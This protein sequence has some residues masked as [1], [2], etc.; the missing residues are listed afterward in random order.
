MRLTPLTD[1]LGAEVEDIDLSRPLADVDLATL[2]DAVAN[3][4][5]L[6]FRN[7]R[8]SDE[9]LLDFSAQFGQ[10]DIQPGYVPKSADTPAVGGERVAKYVAVISN[11][12]D[13]GKPIGGLGDGEAVWHADMT[14][15]PAPPAI[16]ALYALEVPPEGGDTYFLSLNH[17]FETLPEALR[18]RVQK[19]QLKHDFTYNSAGEVRRG[20]VETDD[21][22]HSPGWVHSL[23]VR[24]P[25]TGKK[26]LLLGR[27]RNASIVGLPLEESEALL[28][29]LW[30]HATRASQAWSQR[31]KVGDLVMWDNVA[32]MHRRDSF[33]RDSRR[34][35]H[36]TQICGAPLQ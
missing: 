8:L 2:R 16:C 24:H 21:P 7:Q 15:I 31:W 10:L 1:H 33:P 35:M 28:D 36:R 30:A 14:Y 19:L 18:E 13:N 11:V 27:R 6:R 22:R 29:Q 5:V 34:V 12:I 20:V 23:V 25:R 3:Y 9:A 4:C 17:A 32:S 26:L